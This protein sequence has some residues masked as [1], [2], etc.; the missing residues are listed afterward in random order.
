L[1]V[2]A[3]AAALTTAPR[4]A[5]ADTYPSRP[6]H[7]VVGF[8]AGLA[9]D[10]V[11]RL[12]GQ[13]LSQRLRQ[14]IAF[15]DRP[16]AGTNIAAEA[17]VRAAPD[18]YTLLF[19]SESNAINTSLYSQLDFNFVR[20]IAP[21]AIIGVAPFVM[22]TAPSLPVKGVAGFIAYAK[23]NPGKVK[24]ASP[25]TGSS[26]HIFGELFRMLTGIAWLDVP[27][28]GS[29]FSDLL[30]GQVQ[31]SFTTIADSLGY[32]KAGKLRPLAVTTATRAQLLPEVPAMA[33]FVA[34][35]A[36][37]GWYGIGAPQGT[38]AAIVAKLNDDIN[39][40]VAD[41]TTKARLV[42][43]GVEPATMSPAAFGQFIAA[44]TE[45]WAKVIRF[46]NIKAE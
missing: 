17:V 14:P 1:Q 29:F 13:G 34:G 24:F 31:V 5:R 33:D 20:D 43:L 36:A 16:G 28:R 9:P 18:G 19:I 41:P 44:E 21:I 23:A 3:G 10:I 27:Y 46:A 32:I 37:S 4:G 26:T 25:G 2:A 35:Y 39:G 40:V 30:A 38:P 42:A 45:K 6:L 7:L 8:P 12:V 15:A 11:A 22:V